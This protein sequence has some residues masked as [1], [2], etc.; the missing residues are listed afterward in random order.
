VQGRPKDFKTN[1]R[2]RHYRRTLKLSKGGRPRPKKRWVH[3]GKGREALRALWRG[4][5]EKKIR[6][7]EAAQLGKRKGRHHQLEDLKERM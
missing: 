7:I 5:R 6:A 1:T 4:E 2:K 3:Q